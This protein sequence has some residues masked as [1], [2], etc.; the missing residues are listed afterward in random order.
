LGEVVTYTV[1]MLPLEVSLRKSVYCLFFDA[2]KVLLTKMRNTKER[3]AVIAGIRIY[4]FLI[5]FI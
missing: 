3:T 1:E 4:L 5:L 2:L